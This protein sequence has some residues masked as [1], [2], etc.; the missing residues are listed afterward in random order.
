MN[1]EFDGVA[2]MQPCCSVESRVLSLFFSIARCPTQR[3]GLVCSAAKNTK[4]VNKLF[5]NRQDCHF[6]TADIPMSLN[7][8]P[9][10]LFTSFSCLSQ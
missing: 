9:L 1:V 6:S 7:H 8:R 2:K 5:P 10:R 3:S 4:G